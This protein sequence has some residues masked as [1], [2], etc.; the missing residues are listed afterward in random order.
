MSLI[1]LIISIIIII[2]LC[3]L[4]W[5]GVPILLPDTITPRNKQRIAILCCILIVL[6]WFA[7]GFEAY[8]APW[9][10]RDGSRRS[11]R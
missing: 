9:R 6:I 11:L 3:S 2:I 4:T 1:A 8:D 10:F 5:W 7:G